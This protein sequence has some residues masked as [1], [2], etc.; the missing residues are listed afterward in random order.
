MIIPKP[1]DAK[2]KYYLL[3]LLR[4]LLTEKTLRNQLQF[5]GGT[6]AALRGLLDRFSVDLDFDLTMT[7]GIKVDKRIVRKICHD[8]FSKL[9]FEVKDESKQHLQFFL[10]YEAK[11]GERNT[12]KLEINDQPSK[13]NTYEKV[14][15]K[16]INMYCNSHT[17]ETMVANKMV[18]C[19]A[20][21][22]RNKKI[23]GRDFYDLHHFL[24]AGLG[25]N[26]DVVEDFVGMKYKNYLQKLVDFIDTRV[27]DK[28]LNQDLSPLIELSKL[29]LVIKNLRVE[30]IGLLKDEIERS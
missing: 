15:L 30:L 12:I 24:M 10:R 9:G 16:E 17:I 14:H 6:C 23:A 25:V 21:F 11:A 22:E 26:K 7:E 8:I 4:E 27:T 3:R 5:K 18:A 28:L 1:S 20:R 2:H 29:R 19:M 13:K